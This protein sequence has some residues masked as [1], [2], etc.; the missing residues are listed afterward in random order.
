MENE[1]WMVLDYMDRGS[2]LDQLHVLKEKKI[3]GFALPVVKL[4]LKETLQALRYLHQQNMIH[5][6]IKVWG[7]G[8]RFSILV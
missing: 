8:F 4:I 3:E 2:C 1:L 5:R 6:D 7:S